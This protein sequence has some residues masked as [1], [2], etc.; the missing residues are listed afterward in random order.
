MTFDDLCAHYGNAN[1]AAAEL[2]MHR[3][4]VYRWKDGIPMEAQID[5]EVATG[6]K[7][8]ADLTPEQRRVLGKQ[9]AVA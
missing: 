4:R 9:K 2:G 8:K 5:I 1:K 3:Q 6:G 7:L